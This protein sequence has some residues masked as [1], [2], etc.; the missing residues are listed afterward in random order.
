MDL[1]LFLVYVAAATLIL[2]LR[3]VSVLREHF[4]PNRSHHRISITT[5]G[6]KSACSAIRLHRK[7]NPGLTRPPCS[8]ARRDWGVI[9]QILVTLASLPLG[10]SL[11]AS[12]EPTVTTD[13]VVICATAADAKSYAA[14][15]KHGIKSAIE[16]E[17]N[18]K[19]C[20]VAKIAFLPGKQIDLVEDKDA[21]Y[22]ITE[23]LIVAVSTPDGLLKIG[24]N[25]AY[26]LLRLP[27]Q[28]F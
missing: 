13:N 7:R 23:I 9:F 17:T 28:Q 15:H 14:R 10:L 6:T 8:L 11:C 22:T 25:L 26:T 24:P 20:L 21:T 16:C 5:S 18:A 2:L 1:F 19:T 12:A 3:G 27:E 4:A